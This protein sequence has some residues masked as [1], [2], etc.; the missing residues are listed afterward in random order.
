MFYTLT[1]NIITIQQVKKCKDIYEKLIFQNCL[2]SYRCRPKLLSPSLDVSFS[3]FAPPLM[4]GAKEGCL[5][6]LTLRRCIRTP[7]RAC[8]VFDPEAQTRRERSRRG[9][10]SQIRIKGRGDFPLVG[11]PYPTTLFYFFRDLAKNN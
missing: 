3:L 10:G 5:L 4:G 7:T 11:H 2:G 1:P 6:T 8:P 9:R